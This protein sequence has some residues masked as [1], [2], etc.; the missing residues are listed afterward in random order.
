MK[1][2]VHLNDQIR[3]EVAN[4]EA[5]CE[6]LGNKLKQIFKED[7]HRIN[8]IVVI[9]LIREKKGKPASKG[10]IFN[11]SYESYIELG[12]EKENVYFPNAYIPIWKCKQEMFHTVGYLITLNLQALEKKIKR[13]I[14]E[15]WEDHKGELEINEEN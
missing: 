5:E 9:E 6:L 11:S 8:E 13:I 1:L 4:I 2:I 12:V 7:F 10:D 15:M 14:L 3:E